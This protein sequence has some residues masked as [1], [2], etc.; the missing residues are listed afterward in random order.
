MS[1]FQEMVVENAASSMEQA[2][3]ADTPVGAGEDVV[4]AADLLTEETAPEQSEGETVKP[5]EPKATEP[6]Q[7]ADAAPEPKTYTQKEF[8]EAV[9]RRTQYIRKGLEEEREKDPYWQ[10]GKRLAQLQSL[11][12][13]VDPSVAIQKVLSD[14]FERQAEALSNDPKAIA[15]L[16]LGNQIGMQ[17]MPAPKAQQQNDTREVARSIAQDITA[18]VENGE[19]PQGFQLDDYVKVYPDFI[20][21]CAEYGVRAAIRTV[22]ALQATQQQQQKTLQKAAANN[23]LPRPIRPGANVQEDGQIDYSKLSKEEFQRVKQ[24][25]HEEYLRGKTVRI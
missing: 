7:Q 3:A 20:S 8:D 22:K 5:E 18:C 6:P 19:L 21:D 15:R 11:S 24:R 1:D 17:P 12:D 25:M 2:S 4:S 14:G 10:A 9:R 23:A 16:L 13:G